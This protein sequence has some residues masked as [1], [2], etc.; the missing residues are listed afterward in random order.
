MLRSRGA[1]LRSGTLEHRSR[2]ARLRS[3]AI[4]LGSKATQLRSRTFPLRSRT[5]PLRSR[6]TLLRSKGCVRGCKEALLRSSK[7]GKP[8]FLAKISELARFFPI[9]AGKSIHQHQRRR[10]FL[11]LRS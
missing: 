5:F 2:D 11:P 8:G 3:W 6:T 7:A 1:G 10:V 4:G 9:H